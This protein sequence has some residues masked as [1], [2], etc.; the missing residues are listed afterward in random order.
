MHECTH[1][2]TCIVHMHVLYMCMYMYVCMYVYMYRDMHISSIIW[3]IQELRGTQIPL[4][5]F[6]YIQLLYLYISAHMCACVCTYVS[7]CLCVSVCACMYHI[8]HA[9]LKSTYLNFYQQRYLN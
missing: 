1:I 7:V 8:S 4:L 3:L 9:V 6:T 5:I 2:R